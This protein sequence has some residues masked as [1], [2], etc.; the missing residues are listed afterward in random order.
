MLYA[1]L[2]LPRKCRAAGTRNDILKRQ[3]S[4]RDLRLIEE[5]IAARFHQPTECIWKTLA[6]VIIPASGQLGAV[7]KVY[8]KDSPYDKIDIKEHGGHTYDDEF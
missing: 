3:E 2:A 4:G 1:L 7:D 5:K 6:C 8:I